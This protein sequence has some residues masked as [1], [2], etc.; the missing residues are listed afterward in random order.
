M[1]Y[2]TAIIASLLGCAEDDARVAR[3]LM[4]VQAQIHSL[5]VKNPIADRL[6]PERPVTAAGVSAIARHIA[7]FSLAGIRAT[8][9]A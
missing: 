7:R 8:A 6:V 4:S 9:A 1:A 2:L 5:L 3:C